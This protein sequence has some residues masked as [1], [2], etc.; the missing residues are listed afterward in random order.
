MEKKA[1]KKIDSLLTI[2]LINTLYCGP[3]KMNN[4]PLAVEASKKA[5]MSILDKP[6]FKG[7]ENGHYELN[8]DV[9]AFLH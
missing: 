4:G 6:L 7:Q 8:I 1:G 5:I 2:N 3:G 9:S